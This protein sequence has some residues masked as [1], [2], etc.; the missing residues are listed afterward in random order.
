MQLLNLSGYGPATRVNQAPLAINEAVIATA[1]AIQAEM[2]KM[3]WV[4]EALPYAQFMTAVT[5]TGTPSLAWFK[6]L[7]CLTYETR[8][9]GKLRNERPWLE[10]VRG[11]LATVKEIFLPPLVPSWLLAVGID[12]ATYLAL[13]GS[14]WTEILPVYSEPWDILRVK[15]FIATQ[16]HQ[17]EVRN[18]AALAAAQEAML[19]EIYDDINLLSA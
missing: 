1:F 17:E 5:V 16:R 15:T 2:G 19:Q 4:W 7:P 6:C 12:Q 8:D 9:Y 13:L 10:V 11:V 3:P 18:K 14:V